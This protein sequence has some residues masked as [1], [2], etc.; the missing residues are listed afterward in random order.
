[1]GS[2]LFADSNL[3]Y[4]DMDTIISKSKSGSHMFKQLDEIRQKNIEKFIKSEEIFKSIEKDL[5]SKKNII[6]KEEFNLKVKDLKN[7]INEYRV[8]FNL[9]RETILNKSTSEVASIMR[10]WTSYDKIFRYTF[11]IS[12]F[13]K[14]NHNYNKI[15]K[16]IA[17]ELSIN[18]LIN[19]SKSD[20]CWRLYKNNI[21]E[22]LL[23]QCLKNENYKR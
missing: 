16:M 17:N 4:L 11:R 6:S 8:R 7:D 19:K 12:K 5:L 15:D 10:K 23:I 20:I 1:M 2:L 21:D 13:I 18:S 14:K 9:K 3:A 22:K